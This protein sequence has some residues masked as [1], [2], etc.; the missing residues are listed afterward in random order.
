[1]GSYQV[2]PAWRL[3]MNDLNIN[4]VNVLKRAGLPADLFGRE[5]SSLTTDEW[6]ALWRGMEE[7]SGDP[8]LPLTIGSAL[9]VEGF[10][11]PVFAA[12]C[13]ADLNQALGRIAHYKRLVMPMKLHVEVG[14]KAT[15]LGLEWFETVNAPPRGLVATE[16]VFFVQ[17]TRIATRQKIQPLAVRSPVDL[18]PKDVYREYFGTEVKNG[19]RP[20]L[21]FSASDAEAPFLTANK[22]MWDFFVADLKRQLSELDGAA[23]TLHRT[24][25]ALL[26]LLPAGAASMGE[27]ARKLGTSTRT[28]QRKLKQEGKSFQEMLAKTREELA[29]HYLKSSDLSGAEI[30]FLLGYDDPNSFFR[31]FHSWTGVTPQQVKGEILATV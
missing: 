8:T 1:M 21:V 12:L 9:S 16:L 5:K 22:Q 23:S 27:V 26:E 30:S 2:K 28:L 19:K 6:F 17:L 29:R 7:E 11:P 15:S 14:D 10:D 31:A 24:R 3:M 20:T 13:S 4:P 18:E 25:A